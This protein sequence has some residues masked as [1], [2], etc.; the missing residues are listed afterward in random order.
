MFHATARTIAREF[1]GVQARERVAGI[2]RT[3]RYFSFDKFHETAAYCADEMRRAGLQHVEA[4][5]YI[6][7]GTTA[8]GDWIIP[9]AWDAQDAVLEIIEPSDAAGVLTRYRDEPCS[10]L[11]YSAPTPPGGLEAELIP[12]GEGGRPEDYEGKTV[13]GQI[14]VLRGSPRAARAFARER[15]AAGMVYARGRP[16]ERS[17]VLWDNYSFAPR[18][19]EGLFGFSLSAAQ[20]D[21]LH[22]LIERERIHGRTVRVRA[23]VETKLYDGTSDAVVGVL[24]G[25]TQEEV[26]G[27]AHL[28]EPGAN[29]NASGAGVLL[30]AFRALNVLIES[31]A[32]PRPRRGLRILLVFECGGTIAYGST[33]REI[34]SRTIAAINPDM[35]GED[36][37]LCHSGLRV[38]RVPDSAPSFTDV[39]IERLIRE[40]VAERD[41]LFRWRTGPYMICDN[42]LSDPAIG[43]PTPALIS[44]PDRFYHSSLDT[45]DK[46]S[47]EGLA[48]T[49]LAITTYLYFLANAGPQEA[50]W[51]AEEVTSAAGRDLLEEAGRFVRRA[52]ELGSDPDSIGQLL[53]D[54]VERLKYLEKRG[55]EALRSVSRLVHED[56]PLDLR[57]LEHEIEDASH[58]AYHR[59]TGAISDVCRTDRLEIPDP[60][61]SG[62]ERK[63]ASIVPERL[64]YSV[65]TLET[66]PPREEGEYRWSPG[67]IAPH[68]LRLFWADGER[69]LLEI[70]R[71]SSQESGPVELAEL[72]DYFEFLAEHGYVR[73]HGLNP[74]SEPRTVA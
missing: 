37:V 68:N 60:E 64:K 57:R 36:Q 8:Y 26:L 35:V 62:L 5:P 7:D 53:S 38:H 54:S 55:T 13:E 17:A 10:L 3:D 71:L 4:I 46:V 29:D 63:A 41:P 58:R 15:G 1:S 14:L 11:M 61:P 42:I 66:L 32:L 67:W 73:L 40:L 69:S 2:W 33:H 74:N 25:E 47:P 30:E 49:G 24:P 16:D 59:V 9:R 65:L 51:L 72:V 52:L 45:P 43:V 44:L 50:R 18:N 39:L 12:V 31:G 70:H 19:E 20:A 28:Y 22:A 34:L 56:A 23:T 27:V 21:R 48:K 6:A